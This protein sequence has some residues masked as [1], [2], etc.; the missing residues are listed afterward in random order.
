M[1]SVS[2][3]GLELREEARA[4]DHLFEADAVAGQ[5]ELVESL[6][7]RREHLLGQRTGTV[8]GV[9]RLLHP[10]P[11]EAV[12]G[13]AALLVAVLD[14]ADAVPAADEP[15]VLVD[16][17]A[18]TAEAH[19]QEPD[20]PGRR[21][22]GAQRR[23]VDALGALP[24]LERERGRDRHSLLRR[25][26]ACPALCVER[27]ARGA[28][29]AVAEREHAGAGDAADVRG[30]SFHAPQRHTSG[31]ACACAVTRPGPK[32]PPCLSERT[33]TRALPV[34]TALL[35]LLVLCAPGPA[36]ATDT[37]VVGLRP[38]TLSASAL[39][40]AGAVQ[41][42]AV[43]H[44]R[45]VVVRVPSRRRSAALRTLRHSRSVRY[46]EPLRRLRA[47]AEILPDPGSPAA[48][49][50]RRDRGRGS[51]DGDPRGRRRGRRR[52]H[53]RGCDSRPRRPPAARLECD[54]P[55][56]RCAGRQRPRH[57]RRGHDRG[58][59]RQWPGR[60]R[61]RTGGHDPAGQGAGFDRLRQRCRCRRRH[62]L[63]CRS[64]SAR[65]QS[66]PRR[67]RIVGRAGRWRRLCQEQGRA[68]RRGGGQRRRRGGRAR[69]PRR[70]H[71]RGRRR[72]RSGACAVQRRRQRAGSRR[73]GR[74][75]PAADDRRSRRL[76]RSLLVGDVH[77]FTA[78][79]GGGRRSRWP[80]AAR[81]RQW[82]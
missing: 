23:G 14:E 71:R 20:R 77:G 32:L 66:Q 2:A 19:D 80:P 31:T 67:A 47:F 44:L 52:R 68:D 26:E 36:H 7:L 69:A 46:A 34:L 63:G 35:V 40:A 61:R 1:G 55:E 56:R 3:R 41:I 57:A 6:G 27:M 79:R 11:A 37:I 43:A 72:L 76:R 50:S 10:A 5:H 74:R 38:G 59:R 42:G 70:R 49:G 25:L 9:A 13:R 82:A 33:A 18:V 75:H 58:D 28:V 24:A 8:V 30:G 73:A 16:A 60:V 12:R 22:L 17:R 54:R 78:R 39:D 64:R 62:R 51:L 21:Q 65:R 15:F 4:L 45:V 81:V 48:V 53:R 29:Q